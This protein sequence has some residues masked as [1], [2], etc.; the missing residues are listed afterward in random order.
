LS[1]GE[2]V[3]FFCSPCETLSAAISKS[4]GSTNFLAYR[5]ASIAAS[6]Q[7]LAMS[8]PLN[9]GVSVANLRAYSSMD[10]TVTSRES[11]FR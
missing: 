10:L 8:A 11:G 1:M 6:L 2:S 9:P 7:R 4:R 3:H 5:A